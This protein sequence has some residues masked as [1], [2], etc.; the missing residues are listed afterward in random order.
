MPDLQS[1]LNFDLSLIDQDGKEISFADNEQKVP[2]LNFTIQIV[3]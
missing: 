2:A 3:S 1:L